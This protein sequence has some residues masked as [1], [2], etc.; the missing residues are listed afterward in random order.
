M[1]T[2]DAQMIHRPA[3]TTETEWNLRLQLAACYHVFDFL[4]WTESIFNHISVRVPGKERHFLINPYGLNYNE[5]TASNLVK[6]DAAGSPVGA[7]DHGV[8]Y[9]GF[10]IHSA[11]HAARED[12]HCIMHTHTTAG[13]AIACKQQGLRHDDFYGA[14][15]FERIAYH[16]Y[17]GIT[18]KPDEQPRLVASLGDR[19]ILI[20]RNHG[21]L[22]AERDI[23][24]AF[25]L[26][27]TLQRACEV[28]CASDAIAGPD[29]ELDDSV[30]RVCTNV[31]ERF[32]P[33]GMTCNRMFDAIVR[34]MESARKGAHVDFRA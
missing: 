23:A 30:R 15:L 19:P 6:I 8:N 14:M 12:A 31:R 7:S 4:G 18:V 25:A 10:I 2:T 1:G 27:W 21:L 20:L 17:E 9:A 16:D 33:D 29:I 26:M 3:G 11:I 28:Q 22:V 5:V 34:K 13:M 24:R 32:D